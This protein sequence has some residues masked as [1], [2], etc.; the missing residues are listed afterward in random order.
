MSRKTG[1]KSGMYSGDNRKRRKPLFDV[2]IGNPPYQD[3]KVGD[4]KSMSPLYDKFMEQS[5]EV[6]SSVELITPARFLFNAGATPKQWNRER[7]G[8]PH[9]KVLRYEPDAEKVFDNVVI[10]GGVAIT[11]RDADR[12]YEPIGTFLA[13]PELRPILDKVRPKY[14][15]SMSAIVTSRGLYRLSKEAVS[16]HPNVIGIVSHAFDLYDNILFFEDKP[17]D[18]DEYVRFLGLFNRHRA[19]RWIKRRY[20]REPPNF[21]K[22]KVAFPEI[23]SPVFGDS[24]EYWIMEPLTGYTDTYLAAGAFDTRAE[25]EACLKYM[26]TR[27][28][29]TLLGVLKVTLHTTISVWAKMPLQDFTADS[30][31]DWL[32]PV[33]DIDHQLYEKYGLDEHDIEFI[34]THVKEM[35]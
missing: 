12:E 9:F 25:A 15:D 13:Y 34:E 32:Q 3:D 21:T 11:Y 29:R 30:D 27:F 20:I 4:S 28:A 24:F 17:D 26:S 18:G 35:P 2:I 23:S 7:L 16:E 19:W 1:D 22:Y 14:D 5:F 33:P 10:R 6:A 31:I 8:D